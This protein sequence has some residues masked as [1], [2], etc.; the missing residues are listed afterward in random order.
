MFFILK[1]KW[2]FENLPIRAFKFEFVKVIH[3]ELSDKRW[4][5]TVFEVLWQNDVAKVINKH[6]LKAILFLG[7]TNDVIV[8]LCINYF[9]ELY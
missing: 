1:E 7:P 9:I 6:D 2:M 4:K 3:V 8:L 5:V